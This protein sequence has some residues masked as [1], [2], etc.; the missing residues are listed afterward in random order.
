MSAGVVPVEKCA[1]LSPTSLCLCVRLE[2]H[3]RGRHN[4]HATDEEIEAGLHCCV[5]GRR[6]S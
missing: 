2:G 4:P 3:D 1:D 6:W 5:H